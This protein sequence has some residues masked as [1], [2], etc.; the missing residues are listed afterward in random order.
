MRKFIASLLVVLCTAGIC[1]AQDLEKTTEIYNNAATA[2]NGGNKAEAIS[3][4]EQ[5]LNAASAL[6]EDGAEIAG[7]CKDI[8]PKL[9]IS[10]G[11]DLAAE[12]NTD[13]AA[14]KLNK[15]IELAT[16]YGNTEAAEDA[17]DV[18]LQV[19]MAHGGNLLAQKDFAGAI[20]IYNKILATNPENGTA[21]LRLGMALSQ[22]GKVDDAVAAFQKAMEQ[23]ENEA[24]AKQLS[25]LYLKKAAACQKVKDFK[26][27]LE[28]AQRSTEYVDNASAQKVI[29][30]SASA[31]KQYKTAV[32]AFEAYLAMSPNAKD[33]SQIV[34]QLGDATMKAGDNAKACSYFKE[35]SQDAKFGETARYYI[36]TLKC[37]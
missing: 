17:K 4:F 2:L 3:L 18:L 21:N 30:T 11:K 28:N 8:L 32:D 9:Y 10:V 1:A 20:S 13:E 25:N 27:A 12:K 31:L 35:I 6:G 16:L 7:Q 29:G 22:T 33:R 14:A 23:G 34:Y 19:L 15:A 26:G 37:N 36:T 24:A 5:A